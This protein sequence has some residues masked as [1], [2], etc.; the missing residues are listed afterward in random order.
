MLQPETWEDLKRHIKE[1]KTT[2]TVLVATQRL[3]EAIIE[4]PLYPS[5]WVLNPATNRFR[6]PADQETVTAKL[7]EM[8]GIKAQE[9]GE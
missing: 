6:I 2:E 5:D 3:T 8:F 1:L 4:N 7:A 9:G